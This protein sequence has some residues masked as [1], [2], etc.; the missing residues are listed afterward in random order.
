MIYLLHG[1]NT[2]RA[3]Q[4]LQEFKNAYL[5]KGGVRSSI[6]DIDAEEAELARITDTL[7]GSVLF[8]GPRLVI[9]RNAIDQYPEFAEIL[10]EQL[11]ELA[12]ARYSS[13]KVFHEFL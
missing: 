3:Y 1:A 8:A 13:I 12:G 10:G 2:H 5:T 6:E 4:K 9:I 7:A 11:D